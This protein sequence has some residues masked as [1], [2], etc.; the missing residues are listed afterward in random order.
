[1][2]SSMV[3]GLEKNIGD[4][5]AQKAVLHTQLLFC[6]ERELPLATEATHATKA[7][8]A[9]AREEPEATQAIEK[10]ELEATKE[11]APA[12]LSELTEAGL[13]LALEEIIEWYSVLSILACSFPTQR[14]LVVQRKRA[15]KRVAAVAAEAEAEVAAESSHDPVAAAAAEQSAAAEPAQA[16]LTGEAGADA[17]SACEGGEVASEE[18]G[19]GEGELA[20]A[21]TASVEAAEAAEAKEAVEEAEAE[22]AAESSDIINSSL[23]LPPLLLRSTDIGQ[24]LRPVFLGAASEKDAGQWFMGLQG[25]RESP[26]KSIEDLLPGAVEAFFYLR[27]S[28]MHYI[29]RARDAHTSFLRQYSLVAETHPL[30]RLDVDDLERPFL[31]DEIESPENTRTQIVG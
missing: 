17:L 23:D 29:Q 9:I 26:T 5:R 12:P 16:A 25:L 3:Y 22:A 20:K 6:V 11:K 21:A 15:E 4:V 14:E 28:E 18:G 7:T 13:L 31:A 1:M 24:P 27:G 2:A 30:L 10:E 19:E 8:Q